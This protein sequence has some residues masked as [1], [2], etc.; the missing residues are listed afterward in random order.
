MGASVCASGSQVC[1]GNTG[2]FTANA[3]KNPR[4]SHRAVTNGIAAPT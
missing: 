2:T 3:M 1:S 4:K